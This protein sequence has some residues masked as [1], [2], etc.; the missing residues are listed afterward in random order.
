MCV[1]ISRGSRVAAKLIKLRKCQRCCF[2]A[3]QRFSPTTAVPP[4]YVYSHTFVPLYT[5]NNGAYISPPIRSA[6]KLDCINSHNEFRRHQKANNLYCWVRHLMWSH[7]FN[8][9]T[10]CSQVEKILI[11]MAISSWISFKTI[12][13][14]ISNIFN[15]Y[16]FNSVVTKLFHPPHFYKTYLAERFSR[17]Y[18]I[19]MI[20]GQ[21]GLHIWP[22]E[23]VPN[24]C[25]YNGFTG[26]SCSL[27]T[28]GQ[29]RL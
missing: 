24:V 4:K 29:D 17:E 1:R 6:C 26:W 3:W 28:F 14:H 8:N 18:T 27:V 15:N 20:F 22:L 2:L 12:P 25:T 13:F 11:F 19:H 5:L 10:S 9:D 7:F 23:Y 21:T 16:L